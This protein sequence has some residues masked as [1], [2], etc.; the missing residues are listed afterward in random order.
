M[1][2]ALRIFGATVTATLL[3]AGA[4]VAHPLGHFTINHLTKIAVGHDS[5]GVHYVLDMAEI[6]TFATMRERS[7]NAHFSAADLQ[8][9][10]HDEA[11]TLAPQL[12]L[13]IDG[14][15]AAL[16]TATAHAQTRPGA[17]GLP[18]LYLVADYRAPLAAG[19]RT[20][21]R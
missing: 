5:V 18:T 3:L 19:A 9:W 20:L 4:A 11:A 21:T 7:A 6:P 2:T 14:A 16:G 13:R 12:D 17:G 1:K 8:A 15:P 10:A